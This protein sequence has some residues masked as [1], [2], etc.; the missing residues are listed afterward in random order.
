M[1]I[2]LSENRSDNKPFIRTYHILKKFFEDKKLNDAV[3]NPEEKSQVFDKLRE[4]MRIALPDGKK[5]LNDDGDD[6]DIT[7]IEKQVRKFRDWL[8]GDEK[9]KI[10]YAK[11]IAQLDKYQDKLFAKPITINTPEGKI[12]IFPQ[13]TNNLLE[14]FFRK[15]KRWG[16]KKGGDASLSKMIKAILADTPLVRNLENE[17]YTE[18]ILNGCRTLQE[19]F[20]QIDAELVR[21]QLKR[22][23]KTR[24]KILPQVKKIISQPELPEKVYALF[25]GQQ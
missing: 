9:R 6:T 1:G 22:E 13:R 17:Q 14:R 12:I 7:A 2:R 8:S 16:R 20:S 25:V 19:R 24:E 23:L 18:I 10:T 4:A 3:K 5:G 15:M 21:E 11:M